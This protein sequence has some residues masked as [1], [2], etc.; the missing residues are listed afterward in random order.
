M[1][2]ELINLAVSKSEDFAIIIS[3]NNYL[4]RINLYDHKIEETKMAN[5]MIA[6]RISNNEEYL[7]TSDNV[8]RVN[9]YNID[10]LEKKKI[11]KGH[12]KQV[13]EVYFLPEDKVII[14]ASLDGTLGK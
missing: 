12:L 3:N 6:L 5:E 11:L 2:G 9:I 10:S 1:K 8:N 13:T 7:A 14:S 4:Y